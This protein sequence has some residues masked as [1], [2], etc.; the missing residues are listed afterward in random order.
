V[1]PFKYPDFIF[2]LHLP[3]E[4]PAVKPKGFLNP[5]LSTGEPLKFIRY[6]SILSHVGVQICH[7][8]FHRCLFLSLSLF[9]PP[10]PLRDLPPSIPRTA[11]HK[12]RALHLSFT[13][14][15]KSLPK[16]FSAL[17]RDWWDHSPYSV[18]P[19]RPSGRL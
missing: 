12:Q 15:P 5:T 8:Y 19:S 14:V 9:P 3:V 11:S 18:R 7:P 17:N 16:R 10:L 4:Q 1:I 13:T 6:L 2:L